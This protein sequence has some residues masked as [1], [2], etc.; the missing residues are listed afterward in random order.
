VLHPAGTTAA[1]AAAQ[2]VCITAAGPDELTACAVPAMAAAVAGKQVSETTS[3]VPA[4][5]CMEGQLVNILPAIT[6][7]A[8]AGPGQP[9]PAEPAAEAAAP[10]AAAA[11]DHFAS[12]LQQ[13]IQQQLAQGRQK[14]NIPA[15]VK[16]YS[17]PSKRRARAEGAAADGSSAAG[18][19]TSEAETSSVAPATPLLQA[20]LTATRVDGVGAAQQVLPEQQSPHQEMVTSMQPQRR[21]RKRQ[22]QQQQHSG[23]RQKA[24][25]QESQPQPQEAPEQTAATAAI[26][27]ATVATIPQQQVVPSPN[28]PKPVR[29]AKPYAHLVL[30]G[31]D[32]RL[33]VP[34]WS[35]L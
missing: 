26:S 2:R 1:D 10:P 11:A 24:E 8:Q 15:A 29:R 32:P 18:S 4:A 33:P 17:S 22:Q 28:T 16:Q 31:V 27:V 21:L 34:G 3:Q 13:R 7:V 14:L 25:K 35:A 5:V 6:P 30:P 12:L 23:R 9:E 19:D 20:A